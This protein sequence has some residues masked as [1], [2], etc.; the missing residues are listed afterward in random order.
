MLLLDAIISST[1]IISRLQTSMALSMKSRLEKQELYEAETNMLQQFT[2][3]AAA[4]HPREP[5]VHALGSGLQQEASKH[6]QQ[7]AIEPK[8]VDEEL[9][10]YDSMLVYVGSG[11]IRKACT[12]RWG[13]KKAS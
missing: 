10:S 12:C 13:Q 6:Q 8:S 9:F 4:E 1:I 11:S 3:D 7:R 2:N 5:M